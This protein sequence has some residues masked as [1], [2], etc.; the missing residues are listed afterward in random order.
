MT[1]LGALAALFLAATPPQPPAPAAAPAAVPELSLADAL[2]ELEDRSPGLAQARDRADEAVGVERQVRAALVPTLQAQGSYTRNSDSF[3]IRPPFLPG[4]PIPDITIVQPLEVWSAT[5][6]VRVP[7]VVPNA[8]YDLSAAKG[9]ARA[10][11]ASAEAARRDVRAQFAQLAFAAR[12]AEEVVVASERAVA[13]AAELARSADRRVAAGV[14]PPLDALRARTESVRRESDLV[15]A[16]ADLGRA[17]LA[18]GVALGRGEPVRVAVPDDAWAEEPPA[19][20]EAVAVE[21]LQRR[22]ELALRRAQVESAGAQVSSTWARL[23]PQLSAS[24]SIFAQDV[25]LPT[26]K[27]DGW[28]ASLDLVWPIFDGGGREGRRKEA[29]ARLAGAR[30]AEEA[31]RLAVVQSV[32][33]AL[34]E[35]GVARE[36]LRLGENQRGLASDA[37]ASAR[38]SF[39]AGIASSLDVI[40]A[41]DRLYQADVGL[42]DARARLAQ[43][44]IALERAAGRT[45]LA[46]L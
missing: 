27:K 21:A 38:R 43:A 34:R 10:A 11:S 8:W 25:P 26:G 32:A 15:R 9:S 1:E 20:A 30:A 18:L 24:G 33:D 7:L 6:A 36:R 44:Q 12:A 45:P 17:R 46:S 39:E 19:E 2:R 3:A 37:A 40:D 16:R 4:Q 41:N 14:A 13:S 22:P 42:A 23:A 35:V 28:R 29:Q 5:G 31:E